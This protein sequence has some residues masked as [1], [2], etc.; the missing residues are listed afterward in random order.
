MMSLLCVGNTSLPQHIAADVA[1]TLFVGGWVNVVQ[2]ALDF[3]ALIS[4]S[5]GELGVAEYSFLGIRP[6]R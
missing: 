2:D 5:V 3:A 1:V 6:A 4:P